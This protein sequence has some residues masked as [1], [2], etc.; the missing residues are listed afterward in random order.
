[1]G[2]TG[3]VAVGDRIGHRRLRRHVGGKVGE[4]VMVED[5][6][7]ASQQHDVDV[8]ATENAEHVAPVAMQ[9]ARE[10]VD[11]E[12][13]GLS[14]EDFLDALPDGGMSGHWFHD[15]SRL[16]HEASTFAQ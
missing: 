6:R 4:E 10:I 8:G 16:P 5:V 13:L 15:A 12:G 2:V 3:L 11:G 1:M 14:L 9:L 7:D